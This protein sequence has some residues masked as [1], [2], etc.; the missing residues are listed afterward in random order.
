MHMH[1]T[2]Y[3]QITLRTPG[4]N[5]PESRLLIELFS[6]H[7]QIQ[8]LS[9]TRSLHA[10]VRQNSLQWS[11]KIHCPA[12][13]VRNAILQKEHVYTLDRTGNM[14][15]TC[16]GVTRAHPPN[17]PD[18]QVGGHWAVTQRVTPGHVQCSAT[19]GPSCDNHVRQA[20]RNFMSS[21][22]NPDCCLLIIAVAQCSI[23]STA[24]DTRLTRK[25]RSN[26]LH[27]FGPYV[28]VCSTPGWAGERLCRN[29]TVT[30]SIHV[31]FHSS[32]NKTCCN[33][34]IGINKRPH[35]QA[36]YGH[37]R[38]SSLREGLD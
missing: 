25:N 7:K 4:T 17:V 21:L 14:Q 37:A 24:D 18:Q 16:P 11:Q 1:A 12:C 31:L 29:R 5:K 33:T 22:Q 34:A 3:C 30:C 6:F 20:T 13:T 8:L 15:Y 28:C 26:K 2:L 9:P 23:W 32:D 36:V 10:T 38:V 27:R 19:G 35:S